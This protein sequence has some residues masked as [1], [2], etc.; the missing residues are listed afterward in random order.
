LYDLYHNDEDI[1]NALYQK[2]VDAFLITKILHK[3]KQ[4]A[5]EK[6]INQAKRMI[7]TGIV[8]TISLLLIYFLLASIPGANTLLQGEGFNE[9]YLQVIFR[10]Y[11]EFFY[12]IVFG[13]LLQLLAGFILYKRYTKLLKANK[14]IILSVKK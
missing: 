8:L 3:I 14:D 9:T 11:R 2:G 6:R 4:P 10:I 13:S 12:F 7:I 1:I 5:Y